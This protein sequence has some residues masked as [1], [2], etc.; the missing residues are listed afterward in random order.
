MITLSY[1]V[2]SFAKNY[3][4]SNIE[5]KCFFDSIIYDDG[6]VHESSTWTGNYMNWDKIC[7]MPYLT[8]V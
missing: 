8:V 5:Q 2:I 1:T 3:F 6:S 4:L 7:D